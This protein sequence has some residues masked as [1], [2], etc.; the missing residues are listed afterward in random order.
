MSLIPV[1][2]AAAAAVVGPVSRV[3]SRVRA[4][5][6]MIVRRPTAEVPLQANWRT[7]GL[8]SLD[9][10]DLVVQC[11]QEFDMA[12]PDSELVTLH[13]PADL[14]ELIERRQAEGMES[15]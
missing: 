7:L 6:G 11:E 13:S 1:Q 5:T 8:D 14:A 9:V 15:G 2:V 12:V 3:H 10:L 4:L